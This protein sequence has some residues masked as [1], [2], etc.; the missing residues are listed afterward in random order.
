MGPWDWDSDLLEAFPNQVPRRFQ[1]LF[2][3]D[4]LQVFRL[5][6]FLCHVLTTPVSLGNP[7][8]ARCL[9]WKDMKL[10]QRDLQFLEI[11]WSDGLQCGNQYDKLKIT[12]RFCQLIWRAYTWTKK[13]FSRDFLKMCPSGLAVQDVQERRVHGIEDLWQ[14]QT[15]W[16]NLTWTDFS[17]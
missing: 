4:I 16:W 8:G 6:Y 2:P 12:S 9:R 15:E 17:L 1:L 10:Q 13:Q 11:E 14:T 5:C 7:L 3:A